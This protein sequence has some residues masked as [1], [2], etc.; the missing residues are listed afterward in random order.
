MTAIIGKATK[1]AETR[2][3]FILAKIARRKHSE[4]PFAGFPGA[5]TVAHFATSTTQIETIAAGAAVG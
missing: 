5:E 4:I 3:N 2:I 1:N